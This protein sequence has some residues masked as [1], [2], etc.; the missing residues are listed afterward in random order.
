MTK[1]A[2]LAALSLAACYSK[3]APPDATGGST[4]SIAHSSSIALSDDGATLYVVNADSDSVSVIDTASR[5][6]TAEISLGPAPT[7]DGSGNFAPAVMPRALA[8]SID[9]ATLYVTGQRSG[10][11]YS[12][13]IAT[14]A[15]LT[16]AVGSEPVGVTVAAD[17]SAIYVASSQDYTVVKVDAADLQVIATGTVPAEPWGLGWSPA[18]GSLLVTQFAGGSVIALDPDTLTTRATLSIPATAPRGDARLAHGV[19]RAVY[20]VAAR[21]GTDE[22]WVAHVL[23]GIDTPQPALNFESTVFPSISVFSAGAGTFETTLSIDALDVPGIDG[24]FA[25]VVSGPHA[26]AWTH[27]GSLAL[28]VD[29]D[30]EDVLAID[31]VG[32]VEAALGRPLP[33]HMPD[34]I[35]LSADDSVAYIDERNTADIAVVA[36]AHTATGITLTVDGAPISRIASDPMP[37]TLRFGQQLF[38][39][40]NSDQYPLT[41]NH[42][43][44]CASC[45]M[46][47]R[48]DAVT[49]DFAQG[50]RDTPTNAGGM[51][52]TGFLF[53]TADRNAVQD[54]YRTINIEQGGSFDP[55]AQ[56]SE[57]DAISAYVNLGIPAPKPPTTDPVKVAR[58]QT[59]FMNPDVGCFDCHSGPRFTDSGGGNPTLD[60]TGSIVLHDVGTCNTG[61][62]PDVAH[63]DILGDPR[64]A[65][66]FDTP[67]LTGVASTPPYLHDGSA[68]TLHDVL[69]QTRGTMGDISS[70]S[71]DDE[72]AL[73]EYLRSL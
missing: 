26:I 67:S 71:A 27:D 15:I 34:G 1:H 31:G 55:I 65:C 42:W 60:L 54:Y 44:A 22:L 49:W 30:S 40:A 35:V 28:V 23:L 43:V 5:A 66:M 17:G 36:I 53:R 39:S 38:Y 19:P 33:G 6:A 70:L 73:V 51:L 8:L 24:S 21:P 25:D 7:A 9:G 48:S 13:D 16:V 69:E 58:G 68:A 72:A 56:A 52:G 47:G 59:I 37:T 14:H 62:Y 18:D 63:T 46:E 10:L 41:Q 57:L 4:G 32:R 50:P 20:D 2:L 64:A 11:L 61:S 3:P 29:Q 45:H 12:I